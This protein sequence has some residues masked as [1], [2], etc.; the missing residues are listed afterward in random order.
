MH[1]GFELKKNKT[2]TKREG[3]RRSAAGASVDP[4]IPI[5]GVAEWPT[6]LDCILGFAGHMTP[7]HEH[8]R[9]VHMYS[10]LQKYQRSTDTF[11]TRGFLIDLSHYHPYS[12][13]ASRMKDGFT[14]SLPLGDHTHSGWSYYRPRSCL[15][16][17]PGVSNKNLISAFQ[18][19]SRVRKATHQQ[20]A[21]L[22]VLK[23]LVLHFTALDTQ[24]SCLTA[25]FTMGHIAGKLETL[26]FS[27]WVPETKEVLITT[28][29][30]ASP[31]RLLIV[32][33]L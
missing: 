10:W 3:G 25:K 20:S 17:E 12:L 18:H 11:C 9:V 19:Y 31:W 13:L 29:W 8:E 5:A 22:C 14:Q 1:L 21:H 28:R 27:V 6:S 16:G 23:T 7:T 24:S 4:Q 26:G 32:P 15:S 33:T 2:K 30:V